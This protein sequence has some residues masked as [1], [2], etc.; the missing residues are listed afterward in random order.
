MHFRS[1]SYSR[2]AA[3]PSTNVVPLGAPCRAFLPG[4]VYGHPA[5]AISV[6]LSKDGRT[7]EGPPIGQW[8]DCLDGAMDDLPIIEFAFP[9]PLRDRLVGAIRSGIKTST[10]ALL[11]EYEKEGEQLPVVGDKGAVIDSDGR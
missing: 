10:S 8:A 11:Y 6:D 1:R 7:F 4:G 5:R 2:S 3:F 9:G